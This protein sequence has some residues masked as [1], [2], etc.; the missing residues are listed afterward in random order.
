[1]MC[2]P[3]LTNIKG[4]GIEMHHCNNGRLMLLRLNDSKRGVWNCYAA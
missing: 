2:T 1:M 4:F 3:G